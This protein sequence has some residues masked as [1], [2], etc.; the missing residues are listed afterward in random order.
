MDFHAS[1][2]PFS[3]KSVGIE[4]VRRSVTYHPTVWG[5]YFL[6]YDSNLTSLKEE[7]KQ[8]LLDTPHDSLHILDLIEAIQCLGVG[9]H[10]VTEIEKSLKY[11]YDT[12]IESC[13]KQNNDFRTIALRFRL[14]RQQGY[15]VSC[16]V[17]NKFKDHKGNFDE[18]LISNV[19]GLLSLYEAT[20][21]RVHGEEILEEA[22]KFSTTQLNS[23]LLNVCNSLSTQIK[24][25]LDIPIRKTV[26]RHG[27]KKFISIYQEESHNEK[28]L[29]FAKLDFNLLQ[30]MHQKELS[31]VTRWWKALE[32]ENK[33]PFARDRLVECYFWA[34]ATYFEPQYS[35][36]RKMLTKVIT[37]ISI[38]DDIFDFYGTLD[39]LTLFTGA[40]ERWDFSVL[41]QLPTYMQ[42]FYKAILDVY[43]EI[44]TPQC[45]KL[46]Y[47]CNSLSTQIKEA[48]DIP[49]RKTVP[50][51]GAK[52]FISIYQE[53][54]SHNEKLLNFAKLDFNLLQKMHQ[55]ELSEVTRWWKALEIENK[56]PFARD[57]L[58]ECYFWALATYFEPQY[59]IGRKMLTKVITMIS[60]AD[61]IFDFYGTLDDLTLFTGAIERW[62][63]SVLDQLPTYMQHFYKA[64]LDVYV[65]IEEEM[66]KIEKPYL[67][68]YVIEEK[69]RLIRSYF[70]EAKW[71]YSGY[72]PTLEEYLKVGKP[73]STC[74]LLS[75]VALA[76]IGEVVTKEAFEWVASDP[77]ILQGSEIIG[78]IMNDM[79][80]FG[81]EQKITAV[82]CYMN[83]NKGA[84]KEEAFA[85]LQELVLDA[86]KD[87]NEEC[88]HPTVVPT[89]KILLLEIV[90]N[91]AR[92]TH[93]QYRNIDNY[94]NS[95]VNTKDVITC[96][97]VEPMTTP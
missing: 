89:P 14:L 82:E 8:L 78:R 43:V 74:L 52:K 76:G 94:T 37:M 47:M 3:R 33:L 39:D 2:A 10:F 27:A 96:V 15:Y 35:I 97:L 50:R 24:E 88:L 20:Q 1:A 93:L 48:L 71:V 4:N 61:D 62:D 31:E 13:G 46:W 42:H 53:D 25:A 58:V 28:L 26:P 65:E 40:I 23:L 87:I 22:L 70:Q 30:K 60:I 16:D 12:Y 72:I 21:L 36:G 56:L 63:F 73:S 69:K 77:L 59:S 81:F 57:R 29:N 85:E 6:D 32:I 95:E 17:F 84:T 67:V 7:V 64:I 34:L 92:A 86:W 75:A 54:D 44:A 5:D 19:Q 41:D 91:Y 11:A 83:Q 18:S 45:V 66:G 55:K 79:T 80:G 49:I 38:A 51:H 9:Y 68:H 90:D